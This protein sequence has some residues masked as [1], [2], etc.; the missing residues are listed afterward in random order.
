[1]RLQKVKDLLATRYLFLEEN[2]KE[3]KLV[4]WLL[5]VTVVSAF[6]P[7]GVTFSA[8]AVTALIFLFVPATRRLLF[9]GTGSLLLFLF[10]IISV[11]SAAVAKNYLGLLASLLFFFMLVIFM[12][13]KGFFNTSLFGEL[14][15][16]AVFCGI[17]GS[18][19]SIVERIIHYDEVYYRC[20]AFAEN[21]NCFGTSLMIT[22][23]ICAYK[24]MTTE[25]HKAFYYAAAVFMAIGLYFSGSMSLWFILFISVFILLIFNHEYKL[26]LIFVGIVGMI[27]I[28]LLVMPQLVPRIG[29]IGKTTD[30]RID[31]W[32]FALEQIWRQPAFGHGF[33]SYHH[34]YMQN[35][36]TRP[37]LY[38]A[39]LS[40]NLLIDSLLSHGIVGTLVIGGYFG[41][42]IK[43]LLDCHT[44]LKRIGK[45]YRECSLIAS[46]GVAIACYG[47]IDTTVLW[48]QSGMLILL[49]AAGVGVNERELRYNK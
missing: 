20:V 21:P 47:M 39:Y 2:S 4:R 41:H 27:L 18:G 23:F 12:V 35:V 5:I 16:V 7:C 22:V 40:H 43:R 9:D 14:L 49:I 26:L 30:N 6:L 11:V 10:V 48:V 36:A 28:M 24:V 1:M 13:A 15:N 8:V 29:E 33:I 17:F 32:N 42:Y 46:L 38:N 37:E 45:T 31:I 25:K 19:W 34:L 44:G 3:T